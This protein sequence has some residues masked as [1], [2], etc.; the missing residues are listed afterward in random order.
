MFESDAWLGVHIVQCGNFPDDFVSFFGNSCLL[1][2]WS[3]GFIYFLEVLVHDFLTGALADGR[4]IRGNLSKDGAGWLRLLCHR[5]YGIFLSHI[6]LL[7]FC[8]SRNFLY[9][10]WLAH[11]SQRCDLLAFGV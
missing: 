7:E 1:E 2:S 8:V 5:I 4:F 11:E 10:I 3:P 9:C 6:R